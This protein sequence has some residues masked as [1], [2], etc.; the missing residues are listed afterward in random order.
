MSHKPANK[1]YS[2]ATPSLI[3]FLVF[4]ISLTLIL[5][6]SSSLSPPL[7]LFLSYSCLYS[8][9]PFLYFRVH[10]SHAC[11]YLLSF[12]FLLVSFSH[13]HVSFCRTR[14]PYASSALLNKRCKLGPE[15]KQLSVGL[16]HIVKCLEAIR[17]WHCYLFHLTQKPSSLTTK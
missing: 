15:G 16:S 3:S 6:L 11:A 1:T 2:Q 14:F 13:F 5:F 4:S 8:I 7:S 12:L 10:Y 9:F 17:W